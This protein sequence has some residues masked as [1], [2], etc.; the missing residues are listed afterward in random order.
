MGFC[1]FILAEV[2]IVLLLTFIM[3]PDIISLII[4][5]VSGGVYEKTFGRDPDT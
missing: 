4:S 2:L 5:S 1:G 3:A